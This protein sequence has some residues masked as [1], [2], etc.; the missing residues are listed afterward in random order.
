MKLVTSDSLLTCSRAVHDSRTFTRA[1]EEGHAG[2]FVAI[3]PA[4]A[5]LN[6]SVFS[7]PPN[8]L[9]PDASVNLLSGLPSIQ[10]GLFHQNL[11]WK[12]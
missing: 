11:R 4:T 12:R 2:L 9:H 5:P 1:P 7:L 8:L 3:V 6:E 10:F